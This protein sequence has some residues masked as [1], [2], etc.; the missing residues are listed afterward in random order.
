MAVAKA[1]PPIPN[2]AL[3]RH[4]RKA[5]ARFAKAA[6]DCEAGISAHPYGDENIETHQNQHILHRAIAEF[7]TGARE[8]YRATARLRELILSHHR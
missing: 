7:A 4:Y 2:V 1:S 3:Q 8:L 5:L 6:A